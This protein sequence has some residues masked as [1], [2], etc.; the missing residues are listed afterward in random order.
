MN[1]NSRNTPGRTSGTSSKPLLAPGGHSNAGASRIEAEHE[2]IFAVAMEIAQCWKA[3]GDID[4]LRRLSEKLELVLAVHFRHEEQQLAAQGSPQLEEL[5]AGH[6]AL[7]GELHLMRRRLGTLDDS[8]EGG[9]GFM[10][11]NFVMDVAARHCRD[12]DRVDCAIERQQAARTGPS[13][14][15][16]PFAR[17]PLSAE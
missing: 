15:A 8:D 17:K 4:R 14:P 13:P 12:G 16:A 9:P 3:R 7:L 11:H 1:T 5:K 6:K 10:L 2:A